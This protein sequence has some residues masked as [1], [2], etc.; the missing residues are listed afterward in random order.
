MGWHAVKPNQPTWGRLFSF[1]QP[2]LGTDVKLCCV[3]NNKDE[4][5][6]PKNVNNT[7]YQASSQNFRQRKFVKNFKNFIKFE[8]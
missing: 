8:L 1:R 4:D 7:N 2:W 5:N 3:Y 6:S